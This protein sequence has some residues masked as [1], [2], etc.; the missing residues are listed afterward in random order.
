LIEVSGNERSVPSL[1]E[2][3]APSAKILLLGLPYTEAVPVTFSTVTSY[4]KIIIGS[5]AS[6]REDW[7]EAIKLIQ[8]GQINLVDHTATVE[9]L[10]NYQEAWATTRT[11]R[12]LKV[13]LQVSEGL[14]GF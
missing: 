8:K 10:S 1:I 9:P 12:Q 5:V 7:D 14:E 4:D 11:R 3:S 6:R 13:L 2:D